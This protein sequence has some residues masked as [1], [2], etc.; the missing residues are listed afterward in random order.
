ME[1]LGHLFKSPPSEYRPMPQWSWNGDLSEERITE[2]LEQFA[3]QGAGGFFAHARSGHITGYL[4]DRWFELWAYAMR[5]AAR[6][7]MEFHIYDEFCCPGGLAGGHVGA[8]H[9]ELAITGLN[10]VTVTEPDARPGNVLAWAR[11]AD[12][13]LIPASEDDA[14]SASPDRPFVA[15]V[16]GGGRGRRGLP[17]PD[18]T[19]RGSA[20]AFIEST[21]EKYARCVGDEFGRSI[22]FVF[23]DEP[24]ILIGNQLLMSHEL[25]REFRHEHGYELQDHLIRLCYGGADGADVRYDYWLTVNRLYVD[26]FIR[27]LHDWCADHGLELTGHVMENQWPNPQSHPD[28]MLAMRWMQAPGND[29]LGFQFAPTAH[30]DNGLYLLNLLE[31]R[32]LADQ[33]GRRWRMV[34]TCGG[35][36]YGAAFDL[37]KPLEDYV[38]AFGVNL[39]DPHLAHESLAG[40]SKYDW[41]QTLTDHSPWWPYYRPQAD[42]VAR[43]NAVLSQGRE[44]NRVLVLHPTT[45]EWLH[46]VP[47][48]FDTDGA[49]AAHLKEMKADHIDLLLALYGRQVDFDL[50]DEFIMEE[51]GRAEDGRLRVGECSYDV[52]VVPGGMENVTASTLELL[53]A[54]LESGGRVL[55]LG[56]PTHVDG[57][58]SDVPA[59]LAA[60]HPDGWTPCT[61]P[62]ELIERVRQA[63]PAQLSAPDGAPLPEGLVWRRVALEDGSVLW[64]LCNP[65]T[66]PLSAQVMLPGA[67]VTELGTA[68]GRMA[69]VRA[70]VRDGSVVLPLH[71]QARGHV[72]WCVSDE[73]AGEV[74]D[75][76]PVVETPVA[77]SEPAVS[78]LKPNAL[79]I[80]Y[81][82]LAA[83]GRRMEDVTTVA[84][85]DAN[86]LLQGFEGNPWRKQFM[87]NVIDR[88][89]VPGTGLEL[90]YRFDV[91]RA[92]LEGGAPALRM[93]VERPWLY[94][95]SVNGQAIPSDSGERWLDE[96]MRA[97]P[98]GEAV[99]AGENEL[100]LRAEPFHVLCEPMPVYLLGDFSLEPAGR[101][102]RVVPPSQPALGDWTAQGMPFY[103][104]KVRYAFA[105]DLEA[106][107]SALRVQ[108]G[109]WGGALVDVLWDDAS[110]GAIYHPPYAL[111]VRGPHA[112][113][114][115]V[116]ELDVVGNMKNFMGPHFSDALPIQWGWQDSPEHMPP[117]ERY[118]RYPT[119]LFEPPTVVAVAG[120]SAKGKA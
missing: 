109:E 27:P 9:P 96:H 63:A 45:S 1:Q 118:R 42:H 65:W 84:A 86:W 19:R 119:G 113:G 36:G 78:R 106:P 5:E 104:H 58:Q 64:F 89:P 73:P 52:V 77:L 35:G 57:R 91:D 92:L 69:P 49:A 87:R 23:C 17:S 20:E 105:V 114:R 88:P 7:G 54:Y 48:P 12:G 59:A 108:L 68:T 33:L 41:A 60:E 10:P 44:T 29:L 76:E 66:E 72:L 4:T 53:R 80:D 70:E 43:A 117:G 83:E 50:G 28:A 25:L 95:I 82:D 56:V 97:L 71:L 75:E 39:V 103:C 37:F 47:G 67:S 30:P 11:V 120:A 32:S 81:C 93:A 6:L 34:E 31:L 46:F 100:V 2:Q 21:H 90:T 94:S 18:L 24:H 111:E 38:L 13:A 3:A 22:R 99:Q 107:C 55:A 61:G 14:R 98:V 26:N 79:C 85:L 40:V 62:D 112:A 74:P 116:L 102:F 15:L 110:A 115:H 8:R 51:L 101:G 16:L